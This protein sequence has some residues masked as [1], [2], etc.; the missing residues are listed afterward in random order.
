MKAPTCGFRFSATDGVFIMGLA[1]AGWL[2]KDLLG[3]M[4]G[5]F[6][7]VP[8]HFFLFCNV[9]RI[10]RAFELTWTGVFLVLVVGWIF[11]GD[12]DWWRIMAILTPLTL[13]LIGMEMRS[14][15]YH[16]IL[17]RRINADHI[18]EWLSER[19]TPAQRAPPA[20]SRRN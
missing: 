6:I 18:D 4:V 9:F 5:V 2:L 1:I 3:P 20:L 8:V 14:P 13:G 17:C 16:G 15:R 11:T 19:T 10:R 12:I 7:V